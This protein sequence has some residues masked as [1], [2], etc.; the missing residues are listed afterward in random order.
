M[1]YVYGEGWDFGEV[2]N[3][4]RGVNA[5][6]LNMLGTRIGTFNDRLRDAVRGGSPFLNQQVQ[7]YA[8]GLYTYPNEIVL[9]TNKSQLT[10]LLS[11]KD[12]IRISL[13]GNLAGFQFENALGE[14]V[15]GNEIDYNGV[16]AGY[17]SSP[18]ENIAYISAHDNETLFDA[19]QYKAPLTATFMERVLMQNLALSLV[20][21]SQGIPF[22]H[23]GCE[24]LRSKSLD[25]DSYDSTDWFNAIDWMYEDN[26][27]GHGLPLR[28]KNHLMWPVIRKLLGNPNLLPDPNVF[29]TSL[30][31]FESALKIRCSSPLFRLPKAELI[32]Q[33]VRFH[34]T[35]P[36]QIPGLIAMSIHDEIGLDNNYAWI[37]VFFNAEPKPVKYIFSKWDL[38]NLR[39][40][41]DQVTDVYGSP[42]DFDPAS[43]AFMIPGFATVVFV[44]EKLQAGLA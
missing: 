1:V 15:S 44:G 31:L 9:N 3:N 11:L 17:A 19:I 25:R 4:A 16:P 36:G 23:A 33:S 13:A 20:A 12:Q 35:G 2:G 21:F 14:T 18:E 28:D 30:R 27:W 34:N 6:Q 29:Q 32:C 38:Y 24:I 39:L 7:G 8:T 22:F 37:I 10:V 43:Q 41:P 40:H 5:S 42:I 26:N